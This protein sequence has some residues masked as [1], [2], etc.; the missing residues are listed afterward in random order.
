MTSRFG[1]VQGVTGPS[2]YN[3]PNIICTT[4]KK[5]KSHKILSTWQGQAGVKGDKVWGDYLQNLM[6]HT[7]E[8]ETKVCS[9]FSH[10]FRLS[11][12]SSSRSE[13]RC[14]SPETTIW[15]KSS[16]K[17]ITCSL[18]TRRKEVLKLQFANYTPLLLSW[19]AGQTEDKG[20]CGQFF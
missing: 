2:H 12:G 13:L 15:P 1:R 14:L 9:A 3:T 11:M 10:D 19:P 7:T 4:Q 5:W 20:G 17:S 6:P 16:K 8:E 18:Q